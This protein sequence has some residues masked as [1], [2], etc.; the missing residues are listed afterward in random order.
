M[1]KYN[2]ILNVFTAGTPQSEASSSEKALALKR[3]LAAVYL[4]MHLFVIMAL[5]SVL[6]L[7]NPGFSAAYAVCCTF[8]FMRVIR[9]ITTVVNSSINQTCQHKTSTV[10][11]FAFPIALSI[12]AHLIT[13]GFV[14]G[15]S[16][17]EF[18]DWKSMVI[19][20]LG[21]E[22]LLWDFILMP[23]TLFSIWKFTGVTI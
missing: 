17:Y 10:I 7:S 6:I 5:V 15:A 22:F 11:K 18:D 2:R 23:I 9:L 1:F 12:F 19:A 8:V 4:D 3:P 16:A 13:I 14:V 21:C 20:C